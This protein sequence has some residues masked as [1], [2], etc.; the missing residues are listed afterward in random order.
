[1]RMRNELDAY[2]QKTKAKQWQRRAGQKV[3]ATDDPSLVFCRIVSVSR[4]TE[5]Q[6]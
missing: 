4:C 6:A 3:P 2:V 1:M 5:W